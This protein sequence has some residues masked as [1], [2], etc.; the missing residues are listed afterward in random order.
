[1]VHFKPESSTSLYSKSIHKNTIHPRYTTLKQ[2]IRKQLTNN[3]V[4]RSVEDVANGSEISLKFLIVIAFV[5]NIIVQGSGHY[6]TMLI[7]SL[8]IILH[9][10][11][12]KIIVPPNVSMVFGYMIKVVMFDI[13]D[14]EW[15]TELVL[16]FDHEK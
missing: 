6:L 14:A 2:K 9:L 4:N 1:M 15:T 8:Q 5:L 13:F 7:R 10:P 16:D 11:I 3:R 12:L